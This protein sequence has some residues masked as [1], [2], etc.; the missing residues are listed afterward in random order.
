MAIEVKGV[1]PLV[2]VFDMPRSKRFS[3]DVPGFTVKGKSGP[4]T[5]DPDDVNWV[6][7][8]TIRP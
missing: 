6:M 7:R 2:Q 3:R 1:A 5:C 4:K 8:K